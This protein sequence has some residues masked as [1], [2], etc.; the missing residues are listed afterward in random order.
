MDSVPLG[1]LAALPW[2]EEQWQRLSQLHHQKKLPHALL[3]CGPPGIGKRR[4][5]GAL[6]QFLMCETP[7]SG[8]ACGECRQCG[9]NLVGSH[10]DF[11][12]LRPEE[13]SKQIKVDQIRALV[14][15]LGHTA[16]QGGYKVALLAPA[17]AMNNNSA[18]ALLKCLEEPTANTLLMLLADSPSRLLPTIRSRCQLLHFQMP[19]QQQSLSWL[20]PLVPQKTALEP[21]LQEAAGQPLTALDLLQGEALELRKQWG[22]DTIAMLTGSM[23]PLTVAERWLPH[24]FADL[25]L[26]YS[27]KVAELISYKMGAKP[28][29][30]QR[31]QPFVGNSQALFGL[32][33]NINAL[34][35]SIHA[36]ANPNRQ[37]ALE[38]LLLESCEKL[39]NE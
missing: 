27:R 9:L 32:Q 5:A 25:L 31:W 26:W 22:D 20:Q 17:E 36:G 39:H 30:D 19:S 14:T 28:L 33:D 7:R 18:N 1:L 24:D 38:Q 4:F 6:G 29:M 3:L 37:L 21:L 8:L 11:N 34:L 35:S 16:H 23:S 12:Y 15:S 13:K 2:Q 10:P